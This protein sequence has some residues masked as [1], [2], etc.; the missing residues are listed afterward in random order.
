MNSNEFVTR[1]DLLRFK[2]WLEY[3]LKDLEKGYSYNKKWVKSKEARQIL[4][5]SKG[6]L[7]NLLINGKLT[8]SKVGGTLYFSIEDIEKMMDRNKV[9]S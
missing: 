8:A 2:D 5:C 7:Q 9:F 3:R 4:N 1:K 6:T